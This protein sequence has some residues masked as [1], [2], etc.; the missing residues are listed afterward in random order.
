MAEATAALADHD[1]HK[2]GLFVEAGLLICAAKDDQPDEAA[3]LLDVLEAGAEETSLVDIDFPWCAELA[4]D[5]FADH[6]RADLARRALAFAA[7]RWRRLGH[8]ERA[9]AARER[10][11]DLPTPLRR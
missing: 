4:A 8:A 5:S 3:N 2:L 6:G 9:R 7:A 11:Y 10:A 1:Q